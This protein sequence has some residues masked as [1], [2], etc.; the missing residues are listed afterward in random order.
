MFVF[1]NL[2]KD[3]RLESILIE[4]SPEDNNNPTGTSDTSCLFTELII[5]FFKS[6]LFSLFFTKIK[7]LTSKKL[8]FLIL[9]FFLIERIVPGFKVITFFNAQLVE[10]E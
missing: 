1:S 3:L 6:N 7:F 2:P 8:F 4:S 5:S 10:N 9:R